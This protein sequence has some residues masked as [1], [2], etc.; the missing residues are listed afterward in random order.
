MI[1]KEQRIPLPIPNDPEK[2]MDLGMKVYAKHCVMGN[3]SP[4]LALQT[5]SWEENGQ[6][7]NNAMRLHDLIQEKNLSQEYLRKHD[8]LIIKIKASIQASHDLL[9]EI[10]H[11]NPSELGFWGFDIEK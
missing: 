2:I 11:D 5:N 3:K 6:D 7:V 10:Y 9:Y 1:V 4:L 8:K